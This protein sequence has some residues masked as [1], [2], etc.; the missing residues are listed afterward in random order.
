MKE[1]IEILKNLYTDYE[2]CA[3][4]FWL[5]YCEDSSDWILRKR[6]GKW[7]YYID[8]KENKVENSKTLEYIKSLVI[9]PKWQDTLI[10]PESKNH[11][12]AIGFDQKG[13]KQYLY[14]EDWSHARNLINSYKM[15]LFWNTLRDIR[16]QVRNDIKTKN[17]SFNF[18][19]ATLLTVLDETVIR[20]GDSYYYEQN[21]TV[22]LTT[23]HQKNIHIKNNYALLHFQWKSWKNHKIKI[24]KNKIVQALSLLKKQKQKN[25]FSYKQ[26]WDWHTL[27][28]S[29]VNCYI[30]E[31]GSDL[32]SAK[33]YR[34]WHAT[35]IV[36]KK[37]IIE[38]QKKDFKNLSDTKRNKILLE[39]FDAAAEKLWNTRTVVRNSYVHWDMA[40]TFRDNKFLDFFHSIQSTRKMKY[41][42]KTE[43]QLLAFLEFLFRENFS[44]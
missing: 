38:T 29:K 13:R 17:M 40:D 41:L 11:L 15:I 5:K 22:W 35:R 16:K 7:F 6:A 19:M 1:K 33:D 3:H 43:S 32:I 2:A 23:L 36:F 14:N 30:H 26:S 4:K 18:V 12:L 27:D 42:S 34:T 8:Y 10:S 37:L 21:E 31:H 24:K 20:I 39:C 44:L 9:P 25:I 28:A